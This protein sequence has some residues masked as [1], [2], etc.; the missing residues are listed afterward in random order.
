[1]HQLAE[2]GRFGHETRRAL[3]Q[4]LEGRAR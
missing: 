1:L 3:M 2:D 4:A